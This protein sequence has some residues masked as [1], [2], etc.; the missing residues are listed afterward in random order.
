MAD[1]FRSMVISARPM[2]LMIGN[3]LHRPFL[4]VRLKY[5][6]DSRKMLISK[7]IYINITLIM[8]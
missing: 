2:V 4:T 3:T 5:Q 6:K 7:Q 1:S 8:S